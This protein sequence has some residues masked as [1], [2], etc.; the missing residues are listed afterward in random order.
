MNDFV[1]KF[2]QFCLVLGLLIGE[3]N[4][5]VLD[6]TGRR[7][8]SQGCILLVSNSSETIASVDINLLQQGI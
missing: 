5:Q 2:L 6:R 8:F 3:E 4:K 7:G 1:V